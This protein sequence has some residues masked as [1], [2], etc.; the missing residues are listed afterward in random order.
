MKKLAA[1]AAIVLAQAAAAQSVALQGMMGNRA[2]LIVDGGAPKAVA[3]GDS[4]MGVKVLSTQGDQAVLEIDGQRHTLRVG[5]AP[6]SVG[7]GSVGA[8]GNRIVLTAASDGHFMTLG[9]INGRSAN[10]L[11]D[12]GA[13][14]VA[15]SAAQAERL[16]IDYRKGQPG[17][18]STANGAVQTWRIRLNSVRIGDVEVFDV[19]ASVLPV[20]MPFILLGNSY[21]TR[22]QM[23]RDNN[24]LVLERRY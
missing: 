11:V 24:Q 3:P 4:H 1:L 7:G 19:E 6:A 12:T 9:S 16:G 23:K 18:A 14:S 2:L 5:D 13:T 10:F 21:L 22:F 8:R 17:M 15:M 20:P